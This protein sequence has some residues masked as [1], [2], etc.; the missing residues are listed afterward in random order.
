MGIIEELAK[1]QEAAKI[2]SGSKKKE[3]LEKACETEEKHQCD[4]AFADIDLPKRLNEIR[5][6][7][8]NEPYRTDITMSLGIVTRA[9]AE[10]MEENLKNLGFVCVLK[11]RHHKDRSRGDDGWH[12]TYTTYTVW[13]NWR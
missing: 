3:A 4:V 12:T 13:V 8:R 6:R 7:A 10:R 2:E 11:S 5:S 1:I 9:F